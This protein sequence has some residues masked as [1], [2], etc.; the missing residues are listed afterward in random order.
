M[1]IEQYEIVRPLGEG[2]FGQ[3]FLASHTSLERLVAIKTLKL[4]PRLEKSA[5][6]RFGREAKALSRL[7]HPNIARCFSIGTSS[8]G[9][10]YIAM[11]Y[12]SGRTLKDVLEERGKL[13]LDE[14]KQLFSPLLEALQYAQSQG[15]LHRDLKP[16]N[17]I[18]SDN[19]VPKIIDFGV[20]KFL[21]TENDDQKLTSTGSFVG[22]PL[23]LSPE[24][25][26]GVEPSPAS[27][28]YSMM[29]ILF[30]CFVGEPPYPGET[31][32]AVLHNHVC[33]P[34]P[35]PSEFSADLAGVDEFFR[36][37]LE[38]HPQNRFKS[39]DAMREA[40]LEC[41]LFERKTP[42]KEG[43][44]RIDPR[45]VALPLI[46]LAA[47]LAV[48]M[49]AYTWFNA[50]Q[51]KDQPVVSASRVPPSDFNA[52][53]DFV[54]QIDF[55]IN[56]EDSGG[57]LEL[58]NGALELARKN[59]S[60]DEEAD[61]LSRRSNVYM[62][63]GNFGSALTDLHDA[64]SLL[65]GKH[66]LP[67]CKVYARLG[68]CYARGQNKDKA[69]YYFRLAVKEGEGAVSKYEFCVLRHYLATMLRRD[70]GA[71]KEKEAREIFDEII[72]ILRE[73][74]RWNG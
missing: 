68:E 14:V 60:K 47:C 50:H 36:I 61:S 51:S 72:P 35:V 64:E 9:T 22:T 59:N 39:A 56:R 54:N 38:K 16:A 23:Y 69:Y 10:P 52:H 44:P 13:S 24:L 74:P 25:C 40:L 67:L 70:G 57:A 65:R 17:I 19:G 31:P 43:K 7:D 20:A 49:V 63:L 66:N 37:G 8:D 62:H 34:S 71:E 41:G 30:E 5:V 6:D 55:A 28:L 26:A 18:I 11:E 58:C 3:V 27:D 21:E 46:G 15:I 12:V 45:K 4:G 1:Q 29:C 48:L 42:K 73:N 32:L 2:A 33:S 53:S